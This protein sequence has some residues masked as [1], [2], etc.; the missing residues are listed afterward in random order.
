MRDCI[1]NGNYS[2]EGAIK[3]GIARAE[4]LSKLVRCIET[5]MIFES[6]REAE[7]CTGI[8][9]A[10]ISHCCHGKQQTAGGYH[11]E[12]VNKEVNN[13]DVECKQIQ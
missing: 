11:W 2:Y 4:K 3:G 10:S 5:G 7:R 8:F 9:N 1:V 13:N 12:Y 6:T